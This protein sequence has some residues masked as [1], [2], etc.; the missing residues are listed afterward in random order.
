[1]N[2]PVLFLCQGQA[3]NYNHGAFDAD[4]DSL[5]YS[6][7]TPREDRFV[8]VNYFPPY[9]AT[10]PI[11][12][13]P[14]L[15]L[16]AGTGALAMTPT[17]AG[18]VTILAVQVDEYR[19]GQ[20]IGSIIRDL[21][22]WVTSSCANTLPTT[23]GIDGTGVFSTSVCAGTNL[24]FD[25]PSND[26]DSGQTVTMTWDDNIAGATFSASGSPFETGTFCWTPSDADAGSNVFTVTVTDDA[27][28]M[29]GV[30]V[31]TFAV[32]VEGAFDISDDVMF[33][34]GDTVTLSTTGGT[35]TTWSANGSVI[36][37]GASISVMPTATTTYTA[38]ITDGNCTGTLSV[39]ATLDNC[40]PPVNDCDDLNLAAMYSYSADELDVDF[41]DMSTGSASMVEWDFG[42]GTTMGALPGDMVSHTYAAPGTY[43]V[44]VKAIGWV[45]NICCHDLY[46][47]DIT[48]TEDPCADFEASIHKMYLGN[49]RYL[50][51]DGTQPFATY[52]L[53]DFG[54]GTQAVTSGGAS[55]QH[56]F[57]P[58]TYDVCITAVSEINDSICCVTTACKTIRVR[59]CIRGNTGNHTGIGISPGNC[60]G[61][62]GCSLRIG[63]NTE[64]STDVPFE[65]MP[66]DESFAAEV[67]GMLNTHYVS[68]ELIA[69]FERGLAGSE[70]SQ[71]VRMTDL[72]EHVPVAIEVYNLNGQ[73]VQ[74]MDVTGYEDVEM[75]IE[76]L[77]RGV[78]ILKI[79]SVDFVDTHKFF[80]D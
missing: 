54:D 79:R 15:T 17:Q 51:S 26:A 55:I 4:G 36:G 66:M 69:E 48:V 43:T 27:C 28:P 3:F 62:R 78:Y 2:D 61:G 39:T 59:G 80:K 6:L 9:S 21:Q 75:G 40:D 32:L 38:D 12:S 33:C 20:L 73:V 77:D 16:D 7:V 41:T 58:G 72:G 19:N 23:S 67:M 14:A 11:A 47:M 76:G 5:A 30:Q 22:V 74:R 25:I 71:T 52:V 64:E 46:C 10:N 49:S 65:V 24:C 50:F 70:A 35:S 18:Q 56:S 68:D 13:S 29:N 45:G 57:T 8:D 1:M 37:T 42:D 31:Y 63:F 44:C 60:G 53:W 34:P